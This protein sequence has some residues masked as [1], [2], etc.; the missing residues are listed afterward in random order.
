M[1]MHGTESITKGDFNSSTHQL[2]RRHYD[3]HCL[4]PH[5]A[6]QTVYTRGRRGHSMRIL[7]V[8]DDQYISYLHPFV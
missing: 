2:R 8:I 5:L 7:G 4:D 1:Y 6:S 3:G